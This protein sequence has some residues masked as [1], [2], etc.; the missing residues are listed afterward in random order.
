[1]SE[2]DAEI[3]SPSRVSPDGAAPDGATRRPPAAPRAGAD[4]SGGRD[5]ELGKLNRH[6]Y[7]RCLDRL[8]ED[9]RRGGGNP[10]VKQFK[11]LCDRAITGFLTA[12]TGQAPFSPRLQFPADRAYF[13]PFERD[14]SGRFNFSKPFY[15]FL[16]GPPSVEKEYKDSI[17][18]FCPWTPDVAELEIENSLDKDQLTISFASMISVRDPFLKVDS[19]ELAKEND[20]LPAATGQ[21]LRLKKSL[22]LRRHYEDMWEKSLQPLDAESDSARKP[23]A[24]SLDG[25]LKVSLIAL[26]DIYRETPG[27]AA[28]EL[29]LRNHLHLIAYL[30]SLPRPEGP[31]GG[32]GIGADAPAGGAKGLVA[33]SKE[34][35][36]ELFQRF[37]RIYFGQGPE[38]GSVHESEGTWAKFFEGLEKG[39]PLF[40]DKTEWFDE[41]VV[42]DLVTA[43]TP[44]PFVQWAQEVHGGFGN[45]GVRNA[46]VEVVPHVRNFRRDFLQPDREQKLEEILN[47]LMGDRLLRSGDTLQSFVW[48]CPDFESLSESLQAEYQNVRGA[49]RL[50]A[51]RLRKAQEHSEALTRAY[52]T[53]FRRLDCIIVQKQ[54]CREAL[55]AYWWQ[56]GRR[57]EEKRIFSS[58][59]NDQAG[60]RLAPEIQPVRPARDHSWSRFDDPRPQTIFLRVCIRDSLNEPVIDG[61]FLFSTDYDEGR[62]TDKS[63]DRRFEDVEDLLAFGKVY[64]F[65][66]REYIRGL[67]LAREAREIGE[68]NQ[69]LYNNRLAGLEALITERSKGMSRSITDDNSWGKFIYE[70]VNNYA[71][72]LV[73]T[74]RRTRIETFPFDRLL[75]LPL[76]AR[77]ADQ[78]FD[79]PF[80]LF[81][82]IFVERANGRI[83]PN[84]YSLLKPY[85]SPVESID[86][87]AGEDSRF[88]QRSFQQES[89]DSMGEST[90][91]DQFLEKHYVGA[92]SPPVS[93]SSERAA[94]KLESYVPKLVAGPRGEANCG[95]SWAE[96]A[97]GGF[98]KQTL[99]H[100]LWAAFLT[101]LSRDLMAVDARNLLGIGSAETHHWLW[102]R[103]GLL[104]VVLNF[105]GDGHPALRVVLN[106][107]SEGISP[108]APN[109]DR[110][111]SSDGE[112]T[113]LKS[114]LAPID[115]DQRKAADENIDRN[116]SGIREILRRYP[117][118]SQSQWTDEE[119]RSVGHTMTA[120]WDILWKY[121]EALRLEFDD[122]KVINVVWFALQDEVQL[123]KRLKDSLKTSAAGTSDTF[124]KPA[125][126]DELKDLMFVSHRLGAKDGGEH[127]DETEPGDED[128][129][130]LRF[131]EELTNQVSNRGRAAHENSPEKTTW[132]QPLLTRPLVGSD[133]PALDGLTAQDASHV[134]DEALSRLVGERIGQRVPQYEAMARGKDGTQFFLGVINLHV[135]GGSER[136]Q[137]RLSYLIAMIRD[138]DERQTNRFRTPAEAKEQEKVDLRD[139]ALYTATF[140]RNVRNAVDKTIREQQLGVFARDISQIARNWYSKGTDEIVAALQKE[141]QRLAAS[142]S[143]KDDLARLRPEV[144]NCFFDK[145]LDVMVREE[146]RAERSEPIGL[147]SFPFDRLLHIPL[148]GRPSKTPSDGVRLC[149][150]RLQVKNRKD[151]A[152]QRVN[153]EPDSKGPRSAATYAAIRKFGR[154]WDTKGGQKGH[155][156]KVY[157][158]PGPWTQEDVPYT[159]GLEQALRQ[160]SDA[161]DHKGSFMDA[162]VP[163]L[164]EAKS[165][166]AL[167]QAGLI[168]HLLQCT[169]QTAEGKKKSQIWQAATRLS[170]ILDDRIRS[171]ERQERANV[172]VL[173]QVLAHR[174]VLKP[175]AARAGGLPAASADLLLFRE[176]FEAV[177]GESGE[178]IYGLGDE[179]ESK[180]FYV[181]YSIE[182]PESFKETYGT[183]R[184]RG[185]VCLIV[186]DARTDQKIEDQESADREDLHTFVHNSVGGLKLVLDLQALL[187]R[188]R[189]PG[190]EDAF[191]G[192][193]HR[194][195]NVLGTPLRTLQT[196]KSVLQ[197]MTLGRQPGANAPT[198]ISPFLENPLMLYQTVEQAEATINGIQRLFKQ[199][200][201]VSAPDQE[202]LF[203][204]QFSSDWLG[205]LFV[206]KLA[207]AARAAL[208]AMV[209]K[210]A[211]GVN[212]R[213][214]EG[215]IRE[216]REEINEVL[217]RAASRRANWEH[218]PE[219]ASPPFM[220]PEKVQRELLRLQSS[221]EKAFRE[222]SGGMPF[223]LFFSYQVHAPRRLYFLGSLKLNEALSILI[224]NAFQALCSYVTRHEGDRKGQLSLVCRPA[225]AGATS[226]AGPG[227]VILEIRNSS[228]PIADEIYRHMVG[229]VAKPI[230]TT[231]HARWS[232]KEGGS[233]FGHYYA[234]RV[235]SS[236]CGGQELRR[237]LNVEVEQVNEEGQVCVR[238]N[239]LTPRA[240]LP[241]EYTGDHVRAAVAKV[242]PGSLAPSSFGTAEASF[243]FPGIIEEFFKLTKDLL[244]AARAETIDRLYDE[245]RLYTQV[246]IKNSLQHFLE[247]MQLALGRWS[248][249]LTDADGAKLRPRLEGLVRDLNDKQ[250][251]A[252]ESFSTL[253]DL[254]SRHRK[255]NPDLLRELAE[256]NGEFWS[257]DGAESGE[258]T[259]RGDARDRL[260]RFLASGSL[261]LADLFSPDDEKRLGGR[262][263]RFRPHLMRPADTTDGFRDIL[264]TAFHTDGATQLTVPDRAR[265]VEKFKPISWLVFESASSE[266]LILKIRLSESGPRGGFG[267]ED[268]S[269][270]V[271][272]SESSHE[273]ESITEE[274]LIKR[275]SRNQL[276]RRF[277]SY[278]RA[279]QAMAPERSRE[280]LVEI[281]RFPSELASVSNDGEAFWEVRLEMPAVLPEQNGIP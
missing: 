272:A 257:R 208:E 279:L 75:I 268:R 198:G 231:V 35:Y 55:D 102:L 233:G 255:E 80:Y 110:V 129:F 184:Y 116:I 113:K 141:V 65:A 83:K 177:E 128:P 267:V 63:H 211:D 48:V 21:R 223:E 70:I 215:V 226:G 91:L 28:I 186:D 273:L 249:A 30:W 153:W 256:G 38:V 224:E 167:A 90:P 172:P 12:V 106:R 188:V 182:S 23:A 114:L 37:L 88:R 258:S 157:L 281:R 159:R 2:S 15:R 192:T 222:Y 56:T 217:A 200:K 50:Q 253:L 190:A 275:F 140:F 27:N 225:E 133:A 165:L 179:P 118:A 64:F 122:D 42:R 160:L 125:V 251:L 67:D 111:I 138:F 5:Y 9:L 81:Q 92:G 158:G 146:R 265:V 220:E 33:Q 60:V 155:A 229:S 82:A 148:W 203:L 147:E 169:C 207:E 58:F 187:H 175:W 227:E 216:A 130:V 62:T 43:E 210:V 156:R 280:G 228:L 276:A 14:N 115:H 18:S 85:Q 7:R 161:E 248:A 219:F 127:A 78:T 72:S 242:F 29:L 164:Y 178:W 270:A 36:R 126:A 271:S 1:M 240:E 243:K 254:L 19:A 250:A 120:L 174:I 263:A 123:F 259:D 131:L 45:E 199:L 194:L 86:E 274:A 277:I 93:S 31:D 107:Y 103:I 97:L 34:A 236:L 143:S 10:G 185:V 195:K 181:Y 121:E 213:S 95:R 237:Q 261:T 191:L 99:R 180:V 235:I 68:L 144:M 3:S 119:V 218:G 96:R 112:L 247:Q 176:F 202:S 13:I 8:D 66:V 6:W 79:L 57:D 41:A 84:A 76:A 252:R 17:W 230:P 46:L 150:A 173:T 221:V 40:A 73:D 238:V 22:F 245:L 246:G 154:V 151:G 204:E 136:D 54:S 234:R 152:K 26:F 196:V 71:A 39:T 105:L 124:E 262:L 59:K 52:R 139:L 183:D 49:D 24:D 137:R 201:D 77:T 108:N 25:D 16:D 109:L 278:R 32:S 232:G 244:E 101:K 11:D 94:A 20:R 212:V 205:W 170:D 239:L 44:S 51:E 47:E 266:Y 149:Y 269:E 87:V 117:E 193:L 260:R 69:H 53:F 171:L 132:Y 241:L 162:F 100:G 163:R 89:M 74:T 197:P 61:L 206:N 166:Q 189:Q 145:L 209:Q 142:E 168:C 135:S 214:A 4:A 98:W 264:V 134:G 104:R